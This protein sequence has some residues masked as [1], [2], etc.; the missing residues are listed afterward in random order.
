[1]PVP[2]QPSVAQTVNT[3]GD[4]LKIQKNYFSNF[5]NSLTNLTKVT[6]L[7]SKRVKEVQ[8]VAN[9]VKKTA[10]NAKTVTDNLKKGQFKKVNGSMANAIGF[11]LSLASIGLSLLTINHV[12]NL[13]EIQLR[14]EKIIEKDLNIS[15]QN[16]VKNGLNIRKLREEFNKFKG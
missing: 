4:I 1:M 2:S 13:Q 3:F 9:D 10:K 15:F 6:K 5:S 16:F 7:T 12:G 8:K 14:K 11:A